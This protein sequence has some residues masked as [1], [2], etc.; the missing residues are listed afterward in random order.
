MIQKEIV[1]V[2]TNPTNRKEWTNEEL[3]R[4]NT[5]RLEGKTKKE[6]AQLL[7]RSP[8]S[9]QAKIWRS[10]HVITEIKR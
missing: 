9:V 10:T 3:E 7:G 2:P 5:L 4:L 6:I 1:F 8:I